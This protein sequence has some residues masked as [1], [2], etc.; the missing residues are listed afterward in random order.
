MFLEKDYVGCP[1][2]KTWQKIKFSED[3]WPGCYTYGHWRT[4]FK[5]IRRVLVLL[6]AVGRA[7]EEQQRQEPKSEGPGTGS[8][9]SPLSRPGF[10]AAIER[11]R[12]APTGRE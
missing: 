4:Q 10:E 6:S 3:I 5:K 7:G 2:G 12:V 8:S 11:A 9:S 1:S